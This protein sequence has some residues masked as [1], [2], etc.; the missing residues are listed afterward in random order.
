MSTT[1]ASV[2]SAAGHHGEPNGTIYNRIFWLTYLANLSLVTANALTFRFAE[3]VAYLGGT[4]QVAG[5]IVSLG[6]TGALAGRLV[7]GPAIDR[8]GV[9]RLWAL[10]AALFVGGNVVFLLGDTVSWQLYAARA[11][12]A[13]GLAG[14][15]TC[16]MVFIQNQV[17]AQRRTE[18]IG[19]LG[20]SGFL[21]MIVGSQVGDWIFDTFP[22]GEGQFLLLFGGA[23]GL[24]ALHLAIVVYLTRKVEHRRPEE[25]PAAH[26]LVFRYWPGSVMVAAMMMGISFTVT[27]VFLT[28]FSTHLGLRGIGTFFTVY[29]GAA[30]VFRI[31]SRRWSRI[32]GRHL[33]ILLA[34][35]GMGAGFSLLP[36]VTSEWHFILPAVAC[37]F[38]H[39][40][41]FP[42][43]VSLGAGAFPQKY[44][45]TGTTIVLGCFEVGAMVSGPVLGGIIDRFG[46]A[47]MFYTAA[48]TAVGIGA[49]YALTGARQPDDDVLGSEPESES[50]SQPETVAAGER[51]TDENS[52]P[53]PCPEVGR[54]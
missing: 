39:A 15:F 38:G 1:E 23:A 54:G 52:V 32:I 8:Y 47:P 50:E 11:A 17:P 18:V 20:S 6:I 21:G 37:G 3:L 41:L 40:L 27:T 7:L 45:G 9:R 4:E 25:T 44:R 14:M 12:F 53:V 19:S 26:R 5:S 16:S 10:A 28:R 24:G 22:A 36:F 51:G 43:V 30:F 13:T 2:A 34:L 31:G 48:G 35:S 29:S 49:F 46:F 33:M 42:A